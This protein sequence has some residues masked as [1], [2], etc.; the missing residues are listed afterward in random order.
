[1]YMWHIC[2]CLVYAYALAMQM[3]G[4]WICS[5]Y[6]RSSL[7]P[8]RSENWQSR[9]FNGKL[10]KSD[11]DCYLSKVLLGGLLQGTNIRYERKTDVIYLN[12]FLFL[13]NNVRLVIRS[14]YCT[15]FILS[16]APACPAIAVSFGH[17]GVQASRSATRMSG[18]TS[19]A[20]R[21]QDRMALRRA[22]N[23][24]TRWTSLTEVGWIIFYLPVEH[25][26]IC[27]MQSNST[28]LISLLI[29]CSTRSGIR[30]RNKINYF[31]LRSRKILTNIDILKCNPI[32]KCRITTGC[33]KIKNIRVIHW[34]C[35]VLFFTKMRFDCLLRISWK[36]LDN[37]NALSSPELCKNNL[38]ICAAF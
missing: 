36:N 33:K 34:C 1:M 21:F 7:F 9:I 18:V 27:F 2:R 8:L 38:F 26:I 17:F 22:Q 35:F 13:F 12:T 6:V 25:H 23:T 14:N 37:T 3:Y 11:F 19:T 20:V 24:S 31:T 5:G 28:M 10:V 15:L 4:I 32:C 16:T 29:K 30:P